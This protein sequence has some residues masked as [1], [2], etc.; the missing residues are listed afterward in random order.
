MFFSEKTRLSIFV[1]ALLLLP[2]FALANGDDGHAHEHAEEEEYSG[3]SVD[4]NVSHVYTEF[5][6]STDLSFFV[7]KKPENIPVSFSD[8]E[9]D[10]SKLMHVFGVRDD[11]KEFFHLTPQQSSGGIFK[12]N[13]VFENA[14]TYKLW[15]SIKQKNKIH[16]FAQQEFIV[17]GEIS[18]K[19]KQISFGRNIVVGDREIG[20]YQVFLDTGG[21][22]SAGREADLSFDVHTGTGNGV[23]LED[24][25]GEKMHLT[26]IKEDLEEFV[27]THPEAAGHH[28]SIEILNKALAHGGEEDEEVES[29]TVS[30]HVTFPDKGIYKL[31]VEFRPKDVNLADGESL[32]A[33][34]WVQA[35]EGSSVS[36]E[37]QWWGLL[38]ASLILMT[39]LSFGVYRYIEKE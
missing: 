5:G 18:G 31:F 37:T 22:I 29:E 27:H 34:F 24:Y 7:N 20:F 36:P 17:D 14:G 13:Y 39:I 30:F 10:H 19:G 21:V 16:T 3:P 15:S 4:L 2:V 28:G 38:I 25:L 26:L 6:T 33:S 1:L 35:E 8:I 23:I 11:L 9:T 12:E 32:V